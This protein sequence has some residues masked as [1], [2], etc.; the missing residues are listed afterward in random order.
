[1]PAYYR[2]TLAEFLADEPSR[3]LGVLASRSAQQGFTDLKQRQ[4][5]AWER[6]IIALRATAATL[7]ANIPASGQW[8]LLLEYPIPRRQKRIDLV[9]LAGDLIL[10]VEFKTEEREHTLQARRQAEDYALDLRDF[11]E[12]SRNRRI[13]PMAVSLRASA[14]P[15]FC[16]RKRC[17][18]CAPGSRNER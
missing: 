7:A 12:E 9:L 3:V 16:K 6:Q 17:G 10:C 14:S 8:G 2:A 5:R 13:V 11:H 1:M 4:T 18:A 15:A